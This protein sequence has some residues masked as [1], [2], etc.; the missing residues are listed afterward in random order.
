MTGR[1]T[2]SANNSRN[3]SFRRSFMTVFLLKTKRS[4]KIE[5]FYRKTLSIKP[6]LRTIHTVY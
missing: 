5:S 4:S 1:T 2:V 6:L 3:M